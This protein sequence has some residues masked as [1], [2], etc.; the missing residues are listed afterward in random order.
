[1]R[2]GV[3][4]VQNLPGGTG[5]WN[6]DFH[7]G[8]WLAPAAPPDAP[9]DSHT[10]KY[11]VATAYHVRTARIM[12]EAADILGRAEDA[13]RYASIA[14]Q[15][16]DAFRAEYLSPSGR[17]VSDTP[18][19]I[20]LAV[21]FDLFATPEQERHA[22]D[23]LVELVAQNDFRIST[24]FVGTP[25][26]CDALARVGKMDAAYHLLLQDESPSWLYQVSMGATTIW[27]RWDSMLP[28]GSVNPGEM[29]SFNH[30]ALGA[31]AGFLHR[32]IAGVR[33]VSPGGDVLRFAPKPGGGLEF[34]QSS[35]RGPRGISS[36]AWRRE[37]EQFVLQIQVPDG[38]T[39][40]VELPDG[41]IIHGVSD[42]SHSFECKYRAAKDDP[43]RPRRQWRGGPAEEHEQVAT[44]ASAG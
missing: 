2:S 3:A 26:I 37:G 25:I 10:D 40:T 27:E 18:T 4:R 7:L 29:T 12:A 41:R 20:A 23:R 38:V 14:D 13:E 17:V 42:G 33:S 44:A 21:M 9:A 6:T 34:A 19:S 30:Y 39:A 43:A 5:L 32:I 16:A 11:L 35:H 36:S 1:M 15:A 28:D 8:D 22:G 31:V 24:G